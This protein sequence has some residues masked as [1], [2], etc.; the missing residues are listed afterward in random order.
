MYSLCPPGDCPLPPNNPP[1]TLLPVRIGS[2]DAL[3]NGASIFAGEHNIGQYTL[4]LA[5]ALKEGGLG[6]VGQ[7]NLLEL[8][9]QLTP[10]STSTVI[11]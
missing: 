7:L 9:G 4:G 2:I 5:S 8:S 11:T 3:A 10:A 6:L 1:K